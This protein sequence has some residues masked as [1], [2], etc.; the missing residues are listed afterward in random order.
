MFDLFLESRSPGAH[1]VYHL[2]RNLLALGWKKLFPVKLHGISAP[3]GDNSYSLW[4]LKTMARLSK[5]APN[6]ARKGKSQLHIL[7]FFLVP[8]DGRGRL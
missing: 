7:K 4:I 6:K 3:G 2:Y 8:G 1:K 5:W